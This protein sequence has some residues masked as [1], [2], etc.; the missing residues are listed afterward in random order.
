VNDWQLF[1]TEFG[2]GDVMPIPT[3]FLTLMTIVFD[4]NIGT[5]PISMKGTTEIGGAKLRS[6]RNAVLDFTD[7]N[8]I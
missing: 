7:G 2:Q 3:E 5:Q 6:D 1:N 8:S 4:F